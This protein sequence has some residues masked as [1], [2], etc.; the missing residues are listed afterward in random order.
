MSYFVSNE[1][2][3]RLKSLAIGRLK[4]LGIV[5]I[6]FSIFVIL[7]LIFCTKNNIDQ[8]HIHI[9]RLSDLNF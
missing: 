5:S 6:I 7:S 1:S 4:T 3:D 8:Y 2:A 9:G